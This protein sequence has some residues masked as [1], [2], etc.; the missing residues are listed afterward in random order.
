MIYE[1]E[2]TPVAFEEIEVLKKTGD[3][4]VLRKFA[5]LLGELME[6]PYTGTGKPELLKHNI[7]GCYSRRITKKHR[8]VYQVNEDKIIVLILFVSSHYGDK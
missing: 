4:T 7:S 2:Y 8:L 1:L 3:K 5:K 6:H